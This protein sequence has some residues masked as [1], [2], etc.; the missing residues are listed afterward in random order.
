MCRP[1]AS[2][3]YTYTYT[4]AV[5]NGSSSWYVAETGNWGSCKNQ[6]VHSTVIAILCSRSLEL[7][8][9]NY[10]R[11]SIGLIVTLL[12]PAQTEE[13]TLQI[14]TLRSKENASLWV[15]PAD[16]AHFEVV[17]FSG[18]AVSISD[19]I[20][21]FHS[22]LPP[23]LWFKG[24]GFCA[25]P[26]LSSL[27]CLQENSCSVLRWSMIKAGRVFLQSFSYSLVDPVFQ[28]SRNKMKSCHRWNC[29][30]KMCWCK[31]ASQG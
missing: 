21:G 30:I 1:H 14:H 5:R 10:P 25:Q 2:Q 17:I 6:R 19:S 8:R 15:T 27:F 4:N 3:C 18:I 31:R 20:V 24:S 23:P 26:G 22:C 11:Q 28:R 29:K 16:H 9:N 13:Q 7:N 12:V